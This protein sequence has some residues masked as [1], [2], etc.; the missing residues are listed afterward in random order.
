MK[1]I[2]WKVLITLSIIGLIGLLSRSNPILNS[3]ELILY[4]C[5]GVLPFSVLASLIF[6]DNNYNK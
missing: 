6:N 4:F 5:I 2:N 1:I 3:K